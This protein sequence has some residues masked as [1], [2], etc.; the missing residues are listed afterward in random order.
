M[1]FQHLIKVEDPQ[2]YIDMAFNEA[3]KKAYQERQKKSPKKW[4]K[5]DKSRRIESLR[6]E[7]VA[8]RLAKDLK[9]IIES[10]P[11]IDNL[12]IFYQELIKTALDYVHLKKSLGAVNWLINTLKRL[13]AE[14]VRK[15]KK[16]RAIRDMNAARKEFYGRAVSLLKQIK[17]ELAFLE[18]SRKIMKSFPA[19]KTETPT[20]AIAGFPN[21]GKSTLLKEITGSEPKIASYPFTTQ[22][23]MLG[24]LKDK[25][26][27]LKIQFID[28]PGL[29]DRPLKKRNIIEKQA[30]LA[31]KHLAKLMLFVFD[32]SEECGYDL[33]E[34]EKLLRDLK[35]EFKVKTI[36]AVNKSD[37]SSAADLEAM[38]KK[39]SDAIFVS[40]KKK[41]N[42]REL[43]EEIK[44]KIKLL[45]KC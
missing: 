44:R 8:K 31:L 45:R 12:D 25:E 24:Y 3:S 4:T 23:L 6:V 30:I 38:K 22:Q 32:A 2:K 7:T 11:S 5:T 15:I 34:Q 18:N 9:T 1:N 33:F 37:I 17:K 16:S 43:T 40:A 35:K 36:I 13:Q 21:V 29:L 10:F 28:T 14:Y 39:Y 41:E 19:I 20:V 27:G 42:I 26:Q